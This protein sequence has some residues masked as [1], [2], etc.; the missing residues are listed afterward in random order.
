[1][2]FLSNE[3]VSKCSSEHLSH[4]TVPISLF[5]MAPRKLKVQFMIDRTYN[6]RFIYACYLYL[7]SSTSF[8]CLDFCMF[9]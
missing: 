8:P 5:A 2:F 1:M 3:S 7:G 6:I 4:T 9:F